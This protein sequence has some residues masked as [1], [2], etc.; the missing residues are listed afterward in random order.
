MTV[1]AGQNLTAERAAA[2]GVTLVERRA[3]LRAD[4]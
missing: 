2:V 1:L 4:V 3:A